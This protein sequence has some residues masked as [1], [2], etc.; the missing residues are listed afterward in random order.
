M[1]W[2]WKMIVQMENYKEV[3]SKI[4]AKVEPT[5]KR[6]GKRNNQKKGNMP[7]IRYRQWNRRGHIEK[8]CRMDLAQI[9]F[10]KCDQFDH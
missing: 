3:F 4:E 7:F 10:F 2:L 9:K 1:R 5:A 8:D 6:K